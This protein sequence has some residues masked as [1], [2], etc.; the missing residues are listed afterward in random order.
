MK[1]ELKAGMFFSIVSRLFS[2]N[3]S[4]CFLTA[5]NFV[6]AAQALVLNS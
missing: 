5:Q 3:N 6:D 1:T 2:L 4:F